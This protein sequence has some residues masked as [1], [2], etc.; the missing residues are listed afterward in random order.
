MADVAT[1]GIAVDSSQA[2]K[3]AVRLEKL[4]G[5]ARLAE[6]ATK[7]TASGSRAAAQA[8]AA[9][10]GSA[11]VA[12]ASLTRQAGAARQAAVAVNDNARRMGGSFSGLAAQFQDIG[13]TAAMGMNPAIIALQQG[14][15][16]AGQMEIAMQ[17]GASAVGVL[18]T[19]LKSLFSPLTFVT[20]ALTALAA[21]GLQMVD[22]PAA[23]AWALEMLSDALQ[24]VAPYAVA[25]AAALAL[26]Y[27]PA[28][29]TGL[30][31]LIALIARVGV[32]ALSAAGSFTAAWLA[33]IG[34]VGWLIA[35]IGAVAAAAFL[36]RDQ[37]KA[38]I[39]VDVVAIIKTAGNFII[40]SFEAAYADVKFIWS[41]F[42]DMMGAAVI[43]G[44][45]IAIR[46][47]NGMIEK[48]AAGIDWLI[49]KVAPVLEMGGI[50]A[51]GKVS[52]S[53]KLDELA[54]PYA[55]RFSRANAAHA[56]EIARIMGQDRLGEFGRAIG[57]G[58]SFASEKMKELAGWMTKVDEKGKKKRAGKT[59]AERYED[60]V[61]GAE[62]RIATLQAEY[63]AL[64][65]T[66]LAAAKLAYETDLLNQ[67][68]QK[69][70]TLTAAQRAE[71]ATL[72]ETMA[73]I[74]IATQKAREAM[75]F[76]KDVVGGFFSDFMSGIEQGKSVWE[77]FAQAGLNALQK[78]A[79]KLL[80]MATDQLISSLFGS[81]FGGLG[82]SGG[83]G[84]G[85][86][87][88]YAWL[89]S[90]GNYLFDSGGWTGNGARSAAAGIVHGQ[91]FVVKAGP[92]ARHRPL[93][94]A[95]NQNRALPANNNDPVQVT[96]APVYNVQGSGPEIAQLRAQ[97]AKDRAELPGKVIQTITEARRR[98]AKI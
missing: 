40:N 82:G 90:T 89:G 1:L 56:D 49:E 12:A 87:W 63:E 20:I 86:G 41:N 93:L 15:Q 45:N 46:A 35:G 69:G 5:A 80:E 64:G 71:L 76:A 62:R 38:A 33:A 8:N 50:E 91:E 29:V 98:N 11:D 95:M 68:Q 97:M 14:T 44:V 13:V 16:I 77:S 61:K 10:A 34:P 26:I 32:A 30:I 57:E 79:D 60:I 54:N 31:S 59:E 9:V 2:E 43:G 53:F 67:A 25:A 27:A 55:D 85:G 65:M 36:L 7:G 81:L 58:A 51:P 75:D 48:A 39:G 3:G 83:G 73:S 94:E 37:I 70:I 47:I 4:A 92:A 52:G 17:G 84:F 21:V 78:I 74:E 24:A 23:A 6:Q 66:E 96:Y 42:G 72:A 18:G 88:D 22:W 19:A 28:I